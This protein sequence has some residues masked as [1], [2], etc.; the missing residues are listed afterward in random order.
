MYEWF[1]FTLLEVA[2]VH[3]LWCLR[4]SHRHAEDLAAAQ[5]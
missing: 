4:I 5:V 1:N 3:R 2:N